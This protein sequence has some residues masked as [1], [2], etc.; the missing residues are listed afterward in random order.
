MNEVTNIILSTIISVGY[1][2]LMVWMFFY[3]IVDKEMTSPKA[4][5]AKG[6]NQV[7]SWI[8]FTLL[9][10]LNPFAA[11]VIGFEKINTVIK[12]ALMAGRTEIK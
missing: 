2:S 8:L 4:L 10:L 9:M 6:C 5:R 1:V 3:V 7:G 12:N 11:C